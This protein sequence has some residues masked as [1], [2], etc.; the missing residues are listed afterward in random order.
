MFIDTVT[1]EEDGEED[2]DVVDV[3][4]TKGFK[5]TVKELQKQNVQQQNVQQKPHYHVKNSSTQSGI[6]MT[7][8]ATTPTDNDDGTATTSK[9]TAQVTRRRGR[10]SK[11]PVPS[12]ST[13][14]QD[15]LEIRTRKKAANE[16]LPEQEEAARRR[17]LHNDMERQRR[18][19]LKNNYNDL[20]QVVPAIANEKKVAK[21]NVLKQSRQFC[22]DTS[23]VEQQQSSEEGCLSSQMRTLE[24]IIEFHSK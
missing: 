17:N 1:E 20:Q 3:L 15:S 14:G 6:T 12:T 19:S 5:K 24:K 23:T 22:I 7:I 16:T 2:E 4:N 11:V 13:A 8:A 18:I 21:V 9:K 10:P